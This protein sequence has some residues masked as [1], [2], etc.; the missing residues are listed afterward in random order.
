[1]R[2]FTYSFCLFFLSFSKF[3]FSLDVDKKMFESYVRSS[4]NLYSLSPECFF[5]YQNMQVKTGLGT[6]RDMR[7]LLCSDRMTDFCEKNAKMVEEVF[8]TIFN[9]TPLR[10]REFKPQ[11]S[12]SSELEE[13]FQKIRRRIVRQKDHFLE[14]VKN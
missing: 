10:N 2:Y 4:L 6:R 1:M 9:S 11:C 14:S 8:E 3:G 12:V 5:P 13:N 7:N